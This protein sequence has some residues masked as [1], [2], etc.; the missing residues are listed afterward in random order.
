[1][2]LDLHYLLGV[3]IAFIDGGLGVNMV[4]EAV[5]CIGI[6]AQNVIVSF[7]LRGKRKLSAIKE[8]AL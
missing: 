4:M 5:D 6:F 3:V 8:L 7:G 2:S 1:M